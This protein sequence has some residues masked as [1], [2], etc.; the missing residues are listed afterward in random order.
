MRGILHL[1]WGC[2]SMRKSIRLAAA[3]VSL[4]CIA[5]DAFAHG[6]RTDGQGCH[7]HRRSGGYHCHG[8]GHVQSHRSATTLGLYS[9]PSRLPV[10]SAAISLP[11]PHHAP[12]PK[13]ER[14][15]CPGTSR[16]DREKIMTMQMQIQDL[17]YEILELRAQLLQAKT[18]SPTRR[19]E[20][21]NVWE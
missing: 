5:G 13:S 8:G 10:Q 16:E 12:P 9:A 7:H 19:A 14:S 18:T 21:G 15:T 17:N 1:K 4:Q 20:I 6:G 11:T 3:L 2:D